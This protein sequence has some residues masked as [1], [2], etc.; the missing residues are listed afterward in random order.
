MT[1][2]LAKYHGYIVRLLSSKLDYDDP[3]NI[4]QLDIRIYFYKK[5]NWSK[6]KVDKP[7]ID[8]E[9]IL[10]FY[11]PQ[12]K[13]PKNTILDRPEINKNSINTSKLVES[14]K[15]QNNFEKLGKN[16]MPNFK[17][18]ESINKKKSSRTSKNKGM[19]F[20]YW[21]LFWDCIFVGLLALFNIQNSPGV[22]FYIML[23]C[24]G[25]AYLMYFFS[26]KRK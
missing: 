24:F 18:N 1:L 19:G 21:F 12:K 20:L 11:Y 7:K 26:E 17:V 22:S 15:P 5:N 14:A 3:D 8:I 13:V 9:K 23:V 25:I 4:D 2:Y 16:E 10:D 6:I